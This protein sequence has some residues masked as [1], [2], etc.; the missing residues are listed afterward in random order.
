MVLS[1]SSSSPEAGW[2]PAVTFAFCLLPYAILCCHLARG[3]GGAG[4]FHSSEYVGE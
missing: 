4:N 2:V 3:G 1:F